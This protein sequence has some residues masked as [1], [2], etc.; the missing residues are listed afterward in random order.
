[1]NDYVSRKDVELSLRKIL[2]PKKT[3][4]YWVISGDEGA[5]KTTTVQ[6][7]CNDIGKGIIYVNIRENVEDFN[8][9]FAQAMGVTYH[10]QSDDIFSSLQV[11]F[12]S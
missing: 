10:Q 11:C 4:F 9:S 7:V 2:T 12:W 8:T 1:M 5:G 3:D 6:K